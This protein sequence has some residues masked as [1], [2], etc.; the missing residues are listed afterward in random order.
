MPDDKIDKAIHQVEHKIKHLNK[1]SVGQKFVYAGFDIITF[2]GVISTGAVGLVPMDP[3]SGTLFGIQVLTQMPLS[4]RQLYKSNEHRKIFNQILNAQSVHCTCSGGE[5][6]CA[7]VLAY[8]I[9]QKK[10]KMGKSALDMVPVPFGLG[11]IWRVCK[12]AYKAGAGTL[13]ELRME[14]ATK[15]YHAARPY[16]WHRDGSGLGKK[17]PCPMALALIQ[18]LFRDDRKY[19]LDVSEH[20][21]TIDEVTNSRAKE[22]VRSNHRVRRSHRDQEMIDKLFAKLSSG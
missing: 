19:I 3:V 11:N 2:E 20:P 8:A 17:T 9:N 14:N 15:L 22:V 21:E 12:I 1:K 16:K 6:A 10:K 18:E 13:G 4:I 5:Q 7:Q